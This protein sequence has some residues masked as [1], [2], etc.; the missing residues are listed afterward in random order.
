MTACALGD[1]RGD[2]VLHHQLSD[3]A[4]A[5]GLA[6]LVEEEVIVEGLWSHRQP[7]LDRQDAFLLQ[8]DLSCRHAFAIA[9]A[10]RAPFEVGVVDAQVAQ[11]GDANAG[12]EKHLEN[13]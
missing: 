11:L 1:S 10:K 5:Y 13:G 8:L 7:V 2:A 6:V 3:S 9:N 4:L 12:L